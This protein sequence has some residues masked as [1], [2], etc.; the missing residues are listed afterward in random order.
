MWHCTELLLVLIG[1]LG[2]FERKHKFYDQKQLLSEITGHYSQQVVHIPV[3]TD[4]H[5][6]ENTAETLVVLW[7]VA[8]YCRCAEHFAFITLYFAIIFSH[9]VIPYQ[10]QNI[11]IFDSS[12]IYCTYNNNTQLWLLQLLSGNRICTWVA[13]FQMSFIFRS[14][15]E[16]RPNSIEGKNVHPPVRTSVHPSVHKKFLQ[17]EWKLVYR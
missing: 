5:C 10:H 1:R 6:Y 11:I 8:L 15:S 2:Y 7:Y 4:E 16:S 3:N 13:Y 9:H 17:F 12:S 14:T